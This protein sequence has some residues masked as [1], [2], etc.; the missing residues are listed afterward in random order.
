MSKNPNIT[1]TITKDELHT[2]IYILD[3]WRTMK[4]ERVQEVIYPTPT[5]TS[6]KIIRKLYSIFE[7][8]V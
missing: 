4:S 2:I 3:D 8:L 7:K 5:T 1:I 6:T